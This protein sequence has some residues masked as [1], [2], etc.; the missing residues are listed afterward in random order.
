MSTPNWVE[1]SQ[2][3][4]FCWLGGDMFPAACEVTGASGIDLDIQ[5]SKGHDGAYVKDNGVTPSQLTLVLRFVPQFFA[6][7]Q[8][9]CN[10]I[11]PRKMG[12]ARK[13]ISIKHARTDFLGIHSVVVQEISTP[14]VDDHGIGSLTI[15][16]VEWIPEPKK[17]KTTG[18]AASKTA[19][20]D[21]ERDPFKPGSFVQPL[22]KPI[23]NDTYESGHGK[24]E[25]KDF[26]NF[27]QNA[28]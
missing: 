18:K 1:D 3:W 26:L 8:E 11:N 5:K 15:K 4:S 16:L 13:P 20:S 25:D 10:K 28:I 24:Q 6:K 7:I 21:V 19:A 27:M 23:I 2:L 9:I 17:T 14:D 12:G 22:T